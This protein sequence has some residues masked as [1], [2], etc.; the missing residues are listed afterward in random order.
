MENRYY[1]TGKN[2]EN[3]AGYTVKVGEPVFDDKVTANEYGV[4]YILVGGNYAIKNDTQYLVTLEVN[5][6]VKMY[7]ELWMSGNT[8]TANEVAL[9]DYTFT[10]DEGSIGGLT[11]D[12]V[13]IARFEPVEVYTSDAF[14]A[15]VGKVAPKSEGGG[16]GGGV[17]TVKGVWNES[18]CVLE[19]TWEEIKNAPIAIIE[20][21]DL[22]GG[23]GSINIDR[24]IIGNVFTNGND[25]YIVSALFLGDG[26]VVMTFETDNPA[27][28]P[29]YSD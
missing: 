4:A 16:G 1:G 19:K 20:I 9:S 28:Y 13:V 24:M 15:A 29:T 7:R 6:T 14:R 18:S 3:D 17:L 21:T 23:V 10:M 8:E 11:E 2:I 26:V 22:P 12:D 25:S 5:G 27:G